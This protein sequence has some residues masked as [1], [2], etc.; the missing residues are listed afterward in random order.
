MTN[1]APAQPQSPPSPVDTFVKHVN[2]TG[3]QDFSLWLSYLS[4]M[5]FLFVTVWTTTHRE[6]LENATKRLPVIGVELPLVGF[7]IL[8]PIVFLCVYAFMLLTLS[9]RRHEIGHA[10]SGSQRRDGLGGATPA[11]EG[12][13]LERIRDITARVAA[14]QALRHARK[15][16]GAD[17]WLFFWRVPEGR[18]RV[19][20]WVMF[21]ALP[22]GLL[23][24]FL[25]SFLPYQSVWITA[26]HYVLVAAAIVLAM[27][28][29]GSAAP[30]SLALACLPLAALAVVANVRGGWID[31][32][33]AWVDPRI[34]LP[35]LPGC[36]LLYDGTRASDDPLRPSCYMFS[37]V[38]VLPDQDLI[39]PHRT[40]LSQ[41]DAARTLVL[42]ERSLRGAIL[43]AT[44]LRKADLTKADLDGARLDR[45][46]LDGAHLGEARL[47]GAILDGADLRGATLA[48]AHLVGA[49]LE[50]ARLTGANLT[51]A[52]LPGATLA[53]SDLRAAWLVDAKLYGTDLT[54]T[55]LDGAF[56]LNAQLHAAVLANARLHVAYTRGAVMPSTLTDEQ[57]RLLHG[58]EEPAFDGQS[59]TPPSGRS[60]DDAILPWKDA[61]P[62]AP[63]REA[64]LGRLTLI[65]TTL[66]TAASAPRPSSPSAN[67]R[68]E[69]PHRI[70]TV[71]CEPEDAPYVL[72]SI[73]RQMW[74]EPSELHREVRRM[75]SAQRSKLAGRYLF[76]R[77]CPGADGM[78]LASKA[79]LRV[80]AVPNDR[81][82][83][84]TQTETTQATAQRAAAQ[85]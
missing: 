61:V 26:L 43:V 82:N 60:W 53:R 62:Y 9:A 52:V 6:L 21:A 11:D 7:F 18:A 42:R 66:R 22:I 74:E 72:R 49:S 15:S 10:L 40:L 33:V 20:G 24:F 56:L 37:R 27:R 67:E 57:M 44:D 70:Y 46:W 48:E 58:S 38:L 31:R 84:S 4:L 80:I 55:R 73:V 19:L 83:Q 47:N 8:A 17:T 65:P 71:G 28:L 76:D 12:A 1:G 63:T 45:A 64:A 41:P 59:A 54:R 30:R 77:A 36:H 75:D 50:D 3:K 35:D 69:W 51:K 14:A 16:K 39:G 34:G 13:V 25:L 2:E 5:V 29:L 81:Q 68:S 78:D 32:Q 85:P 79:R 23:L